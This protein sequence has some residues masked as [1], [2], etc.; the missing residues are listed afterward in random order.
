VTLRVRKSSDPE[1]PTFFLSGRIENRHLP[2]FKALVEAEIHPGSVTLDLGEV[3]LVDMEAV[4]YLAACEAAGI[5]LNH[6][7]AY[8]RLWI[9]NTKRD[10]PNEA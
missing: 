4:A 8:V 6:C 2:Q 5:E 7:P 1:R 10:N 9:D 3:T